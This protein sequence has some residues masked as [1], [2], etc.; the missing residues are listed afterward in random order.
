M[1]GS[2]VSVLL[3]TGLLYLWYGYRVRRFADQRLAEM[4]GA[5][6]IAGSREEP[7][8]TIRTFPPRYRFAAPAIGVVT[9]A[10]LWLIVGMPIEISVATGVLFGVFAHL[11]EDYIGDQQAA[12]IEAQ[13]AAA[14]YLMVGSLRAG[15]SLLAAFES[16]L[17]EVGPPLRP[18]FQEVAGRIRLGDDPRTAV[19]DLQKN[20]PLETF[21]LFATSLAIHW[22]VGGS[23]ATTLSS[24]GQTVRDR[25][26]LSRRVRAQ[27]VESHASVAV[28]LAI[29]YVLAFLMW[30][31]NPDRIEAFVQTGIG[32]AIVAGVIT[33]QA[34]GLVWMSRLSKSTF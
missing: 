27:G 24:V 5:V 15:A 4:V 3:A 21:R 23:L 26:E 1:I 29:A 6:D 11:I 10:A 17:E 30:R 2:L 7:R 22:E 19:S 32:T 34:V 13:L 16:A 12:V 20:V 31:T 9:G 18:Y 28:V 25:I 8:R 33:L 14:I